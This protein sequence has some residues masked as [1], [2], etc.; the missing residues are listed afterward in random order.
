MVQESTKLLSNLLVF[1]KKF[2]DDSCIDTADVS[3]LHEPL[4]DAGL[5]VDGTHE[6]LMERLREQ[7][8]EEANIE[9]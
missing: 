5:E 3:T 8:E 4:K 7:F 2:P 1:C 6:M 9:G